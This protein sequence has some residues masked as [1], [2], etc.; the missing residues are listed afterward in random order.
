MWVI[1][2][3]CILWFGILVSPTKRL[4]CGPQEHDAQ[5]LQKS[6][7]ETIPLDY[8]VYVLSYDDS[9]VDE[10]FAPKMFIN[11]IINLKICYNHVKYINKTS[12]M[13]LTNKDYLSFINVSNCLY[14]GIKFSMRMWTNYM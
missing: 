12:T 7:V 11:R 8:D 1:I 3:K 6:K 5:V 9:D 10:L 14:C 2:F 13:Q 4:E